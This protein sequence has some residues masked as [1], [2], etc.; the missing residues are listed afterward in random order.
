ML[1]KIRYYNIKTKR[2]AGVYY[3]VPVNLETAMEHIEN[4]GVV[5][6]KLTLYVVAIKG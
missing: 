5:G 3:D 6:K 1:Y 4:Y 2:D